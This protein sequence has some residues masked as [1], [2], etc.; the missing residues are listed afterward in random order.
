MSRRALAFTLVAAAL[1]DAALGATAG[2]STIEVQSGTL[3]IA[4]AAGEST[5]FRSTGTSSSH[6]RSSRDVVR[7]SPATLPAS[8]EQRPL[9]PRVASTSRSPRDIRCFAVGRVDVAFGDGTD[10]VFM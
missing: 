5:A 4:Q 6:Q 1:L 3:T 2:A 7:A 9:R 10:S 8:V